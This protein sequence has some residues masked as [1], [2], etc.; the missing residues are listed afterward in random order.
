VLRFGL[1]TVAYFAAQTLAFKFP[2]SFGLVAAIWPAAGVALASLLLTPRR[3]WPALLSCLFAVGMAANLTT[4][5][6][7]IASLGFMVANTCETAASAWLV[8]RLCGERPGF[9]RIR[10]VLAL[11]YAA[12]LINAVTSLIGAGAAV[13]AVGARFWAFYSTWWVADGLGLLLVTPLVVVWAGAWQRRAAM[14]WGRIVETAGLFVVGGA[15]AWLAFG[16]SDLVPLVPNK[17]YLLLVLVIWAALRSGP[18][19]TATLVGVFSLIAIFCTAAGIGT[20]PLGGAGTSS[21]LLSVQ[22][23]LGVMGLSGMLLA[24]AV[25][26]VS[27][28]QTLL[29]AVMDGTSDAVYVKDRQG[30]YLLINPAA[31]RFMGKAAADV[32]GRD[33]TCAFPSQEARTVME[34]DQIVMASA[35]PRTYEEHVTSGSGQPLVFLSTKGAL[36]DARGRAIGLF[37]IARDIT[38][39]KQVERALRTSEDKFSK[40][41]KACPEAITIASMD[42]GKYVEVNDIF[43]EVTGFR[44]D[45]VV[46]HTSAELQVW[47]D[48][49]ER[50]RFL[51]ALRKHGCLRGFE[52]RYRMRSGEV[53]DFLISSEMIELDGTQCSFNFLLDVTERRRAEAEKARVDAQ[54]QQAQKMES[55][56]R[57]AGG[58]AHDFNNTL[59]AILG[60]VEMALDGVDPALPIH[61]DLEEIRKVTHRS[62]DLTRQLLAF[63]RKQTVAPKVLDLNQTVA[64]TLKMLKRLLREDIDLTLSMGKGLW[65]VK[66]DPSQVDQILA[67]LCVNARDAISGVGRLSIETENRG[68]DRDYCAAHPGAVPGEYVGLTVADTGC[69]MDKETQTHIFEPFFT[70]KGLGRGTGLGLATVYGAVK[71][72]GGFIDFHSELGQGTTFSIYLPRHV[73]EAAPGQTEAPGAMTGQGQETILLVEDE[74]VILRVTKTRLERLGYTVLA[75]SAAGEAMR[76]VRGHAGA[77]HLLISDVIMPEMNGRDLAKKVRSLSPQTKCLFMSGYTA[78]V[79]A[80]HG[81]LDEGVAFLQ[82]PFSAKDLACKVRGLLDG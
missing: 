51:A 17:S 46:G 29:R 19:A 67:N 74:P 12:L 25:D 14:R 75:A 31:L 50:Q 70:T 80:D 23:F 33:D 36:R 82:K 54:L 40:A 32:I 2:D 59:G 30:R 62:A 57:L 4:D 16:R 20:F 6:P 76:L 37:G 73:G 63:A 7:F 81:V 21:R 27:E 22:V 58:V 69:G 43:L 60:H 35:E 39:R 56:G 13:L 18:R 44:R 24:A 11:A 68:L 77:I 38:Q 52:A 28:S 41:F 48:D 26:Q 55:V 78:D 71:Q 1:S 15:V 45:Q 9:V 64:G 65:L 79:I 5:R 61:A 34:G 47:V 3:L 49:T 66:A 72:N 10:E 42:D 8:T 53:R